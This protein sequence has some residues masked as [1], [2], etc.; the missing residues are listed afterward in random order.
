MRG[1]EKG[2]VKER[3]GEIHSHIHSAKIHSKICPS[4]HYANDAEILSSIGVNVMSTR[5][6]SAPRKKGPWAIKEDRSSVV[7]ESAMELM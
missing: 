3:E 4:S 2:G 7:T 5:E 1:H 6:M